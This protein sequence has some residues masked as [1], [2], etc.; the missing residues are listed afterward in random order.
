MANT[1][2]CTCAWH[3]GMRDPEPGC[4]FDH[5]ADEHNR[6]RAAGYDRAIRDVFLSFGLAATVENGETVFSLPANPY[7][8]EEGNT[9]VLRS[10][11]KRERDIRREAWDEGWNSGYDFYG[12]QDVPGCES[13]GN[14][15]YVD[16]GG[17]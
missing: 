2:R 6:E 1:E 15:P 10:A 12:L 3:M 9:K 11:A 14:N 8:Y 16:G 5:S 17:L 4:A 7:R 13:L